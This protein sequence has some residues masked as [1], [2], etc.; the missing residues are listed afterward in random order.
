[1]RLC[2]PPLA[3]LAAC[4]FA[5]LLLAQGATDAPDKTPSSFVRFV[6]VGDG[7]HFDTA[8]TT[9]R[10][11]DVQ[12]TLFAAVHIAD[13][14]CYDLLDDRFTAC[15]ALLYELVGP[16]DYR[17]TKDRERGFNPISLLQNG[18]KT[19]LGL[20]FQLDAVDYTAP[21]FVHADM[22]PEQFAASMKERGESLLSLMLDMA[23]KGSKRQRERQEAGEEPHDFAFDGDLVKAFRS[24]E[25]R[26]L[27]RMLFASQLEDLEG[28]VAGGKGSTLLEGRNEKCL[29]VLQREFAAGR[30][31]LGIYYGA[32]HLPH[33]EQRLV[34]DLGF[35]KV[36]HEWLV[37]WDCTR[38]PDPKFDRELAKQRRQC[39]DDLTDLA[40][41]ARDRRRATGAKEPV[42]ARELAAE[43]PAG[44][45]RY[46][47]ALQDPWGHD[48]VVEV[49]P[50]STRWQVRSWGADGKPGTDDDLVGQE[51][52]N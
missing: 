16:E 31:K 39:R 33:M 29:E 9:Y 25:G 42:A 2:R 26:H 21:N 34:K 15:D 22:T 1:M 28:M 47:G 17:P 7:G 19:S 20:A 5:P 27:L 10:K 18:L 35:T 40:H 24:G 3:G 36:G 38:Q 41:A 13:Q 51:P 49:R 23:L 30:K 32:A 12:L 14:A 37:A 45:F 43:G 46:R 8:V 11:G 52:R 50:N 44:A 6:R 4:L 48:Y